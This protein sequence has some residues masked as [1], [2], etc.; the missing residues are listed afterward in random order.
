MKVVTKSMSLVE[1]LKA[2]G[3]QGRIAATRLCRP[4][5]PSTPSISKSYLDHALSLPMPPRRQDDIM[6]I[7]FGDSDASLDYDEPRRKGKGKAPKKKD[8]GKSKITEV[9][10]DS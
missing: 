1:P 2:E 9:G 7:D 8:K 10:N 3:V 6:D 5:S 4:T